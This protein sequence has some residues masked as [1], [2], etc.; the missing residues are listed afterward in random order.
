MRLFIASSDA[1]IALLPGCLHQI[2]HHWPAHPPAVIAGYTPPTFELPDWA[3]FHSIGR[4]EDYPVGEWST[5]VIQALEWFTDDIFCWTME[6]FWPIA[7]VDDQI[8]RFCERVLTDAPDVARIDLTDDRLKSGGA[9]NA[10]VM[11]L[12]K[13]ADLIYTP[14]STPYQLSFQTGLWRRSALLAHLRPHETPAEA[15]IR[16]AD[17]MSRSGAVV[18]GTRQAPVRY[19][20]TMQH[21]KLHLNDSGYQDP[22]TRLSNEDLLELDRLGYLPP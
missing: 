5:G 2:S 11:Y 12:E 9:M 20:I 8:V 16:G 13:A 17:R 1:T 7:P 18:L 6:D 10:H 4:F 19:L 14:P 15:E 3:E 22:S 21:G